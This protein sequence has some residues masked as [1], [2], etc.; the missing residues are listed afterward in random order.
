MLK[1][2][3]IISRI[4]NGYAIS[5]EK[6]ILLRD[7]YIFGKISPKSNIKEVATTISKINFNIGE[8]I[9]VN[10]SSPILVNKIT[11]PILIKLFTINIVAKSLFGSSNKLL[12]ILKDFKSNFDLISLFDNEN[13][14]TSDPEIN[15]EPINRITNKKISKLNW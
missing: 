4:R 1:L 13:S 6:L 15:A 12:I 7:A 11:M 8:V 9:L 3:K 10:R 2:V 14:A 5:L